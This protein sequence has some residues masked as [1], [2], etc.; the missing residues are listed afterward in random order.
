MKDKA[1]THGKEQNY[2]YR[3]TETSPILLSPL[4]LGEFYRP[5]QA[6]PSSQSLDLCGLHIE[7][8]AIFY[9]LLGLS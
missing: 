8:T 6:W 2:G 3:I 5:A 7:R 1:F 9:K 4:F